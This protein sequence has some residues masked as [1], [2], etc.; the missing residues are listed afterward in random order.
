MGIEITDV[1]GLI[2]H[3]LGKKLNKCIPSHIYNK[4]TLYIGVM[5]MKHLFYELANIKT[6]DTRFIPMRLAV[7]L[8][9]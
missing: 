7:R 4:L 8:L 9:L 3:I 6:G 5:N 1:V 2:I